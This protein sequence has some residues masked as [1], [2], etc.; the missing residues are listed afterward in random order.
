MAEPLGRGRV[1]VEPFG[2]AALL[3]VLGERADPAVNDRVHRLAFGID[4]QAART[5]G[6]GACVPA[7]ASVLVPFDPSVLA[8]AGVRGVIADALRAAGEAVAAREPAAA[9]EPATAADLGPVTHVPVRYGG[10]DGPDLAEVAVRTGL[11]EDDVVRLHAGAEYRV[12]CVG[13]VPGFPYL[14]M[15]PEE[16]ALPRRSTPRLRVPAGSVAI[17]GRQ[18]GIY[19]SDTPGGWHVIGRTDLAAWD[20]HRDPPALFAPGA[21]VRFVPA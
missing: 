1:R 11:S 9:P 19:P 13:F 8:D 20:P 16:L 12:F 2:D 5:P 17:A 3:V 14:G 4:N 18:T 10:A 6:L 15:L 7:Y 21:R